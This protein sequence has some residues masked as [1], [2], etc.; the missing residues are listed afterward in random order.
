VEKYTENEKHGVFLGSSF[1]ICAGDVYMIW[2][3]GT[4]NGRV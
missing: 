3:W 2:G 1:D 4:A